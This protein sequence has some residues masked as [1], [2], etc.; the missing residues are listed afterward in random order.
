MPHDPTSR[1]PRHLPEQDPTP[2]RMRADAVLIKVARGPVV[3]EQALYDALR[4]QRIGGAV[5]DTRY[6]YP[7]PGQLH[8]IPSK[9]PFHALKNIVMTPHMSVW[10]RGTIRRRQQAMAENIRRFMRDEPCH[11]VV[12]APLQPPTPG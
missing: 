2:R 12:R 5:I 8:C 1:T 3:D 4:D 10:T 7:A 11:E 6:Q 9:L